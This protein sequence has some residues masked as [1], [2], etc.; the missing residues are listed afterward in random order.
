MAKPKYFTV[1]SGRR[2]EIFPMSDE[3]VEEMMKDIPDALITH[4]KKIK[5][6]L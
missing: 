5:K 6:M 4:P 3:E 2:I 1:P